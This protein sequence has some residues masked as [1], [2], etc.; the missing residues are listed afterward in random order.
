MPFFDSGVTYDSGARYDAAPTPPPGKPKPMAKV[1]LQLKDKSD[2]TL[3][4]FAETHVADMVGNVNFTTPA[5]TAALFDPLVVDFDEKLEAF[6]QAQAAARTATLAKDA[7]RAALEAGLTSRGDYVQQA[8]AGDEAK[9]LSAGFEV[10]ATPAPVGALP[11]PVDFLPTM[12]TVPGTMKTGWKAVRGAVS[13]IVE[14]HEHTVQ[15][16]WSQAFSTKSRFTVTGLD[17]GKTYIFR[18][19]AIGSAGPGPYSVEAARMAP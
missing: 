19:A 6:D 3:L 11:A 5:P 13:Y 1:K 16:G 9:I 10:R 7:A 4:D 15:T 12:G 17:S 14:W 2:P 18:V 8:S